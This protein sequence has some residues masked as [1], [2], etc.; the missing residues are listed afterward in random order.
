MREYRHWV[1]TNISPGTGDFQPANLSH[2][3][4]LSAYLGPAPP[5]GSGPHRYVFLLYKQSSNSNASVLT[6]PL[7]S[8]LPGFK[9][10]QFSSQAG[11]ELVGAN[12]FFAE[13]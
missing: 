4:T 11:L 1:V 9:A 13:N 2:G 5:A 10:K 6:A 8:T 7:G 3:N 12:Y